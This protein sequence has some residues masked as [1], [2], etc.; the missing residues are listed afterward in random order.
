M[1]TTFPKAVLSVTFT[2]SQGRYTFDPTSKVMMWDVGEIEPGKSPNL[3]GWFPDFL[4]SIFFI[5]HL[6]VARL[7]M[8][9]C[10]HGYIFHQC[11]QL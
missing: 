8:E 1:E 3:K 9:L 7:I 6:P 10:V 2:P 11:A 4:K 5:K